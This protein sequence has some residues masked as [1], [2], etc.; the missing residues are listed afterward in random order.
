VGGIN[1]GWGVPG[2]DYLGMLADDHVSLS[3]LQ[4]R[5]NQLNTG[6]RIKLI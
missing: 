4:E 1:E 6:I 5:L 3:L 2:S